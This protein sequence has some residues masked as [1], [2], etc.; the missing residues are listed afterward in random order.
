M[1]IVAIGFTIT[2]PFLSR[3]YKIGIPFLAVVY[4]GV[5]AV[6]EYSSIASAAG[7]PIPQMFLYIA[8]IILLA[9]N[10]A[11]FGWI[12]FEM[13]VTVKRLK[14]S[15]GEKFQMYKRLALIL[16]LSIA[17]SV[18]IIVFQMVID[19]LDK[20]DDNFR[21]WWL[22]NS[23]WEFVYFACISF[24]AWIWRPTDK[25]TRYAYSE[26]HE[27]TEDQNVDMVDLSTK[28]DD[29]DQGAPPRQADKASSHS[30]SSESSSSEDEEEKKGF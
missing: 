26:L 18:V 27:Q 30:V 21:V 24:V 5:E 10:S 1:L 2:R 12:G 23:Y 22:F 8:L 25:N 13:Y 16:V 9:A 4:F 28:L 14:V 29:S 19:I 15:E 6:N 11:F 3:G 7:K 17:L 20:A